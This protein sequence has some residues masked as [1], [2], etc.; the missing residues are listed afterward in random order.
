[1]EVP[2]NGSIPHDPS[3]M[4]KKFILPVIFSLY[5]ILLGLTICH[6]EMWRDELQPWGV[7]THSK[8]F[9]ELVENKKYEGHPILWFFLLWMISKFTEVPASIQAITF[10]VS[11]IAAWFII[12]KSP[13]TVLQKVLIVSGY[14]FF[15]EYTVISR[16]YVLA[17]AMIAAICSLWKSPEKDA[18]WLIVLFFLLCFTE[19]YA[20]IISVCLSITLFSQPFFR[21]GDT[22]RNRNGW[23]FPMAALSGFLL[24]YITTVPPDD[25]EL[26]YPVKFVFDR[27]HLIRVLGDFWNGFVPIPKLQ[28]HFWSSSLWYETT[29]A[30]TLGAILLIV[31][32]AGSFPYRSLFIFLLISFSGI[33]LFMY[34]KYSGYQ[35]H[36][37]HLFIIYI[38]YEW[39]KRYDP[40]VPGI[41]KFQKIS[42]A[43][44]F[45]SILS[46][47]TVLGISFAAA[48]WILPF[49]DG[50][51]TA[52]YIR[53]HFPENITVAGYSDCPAT[54]VANYLGKDVY[55][56]NNLR[57]S[58]YIIFSTKRLQPAGDLILHNIF[59]LADSLKSLAVILNDPV[60]VNGER[61]L[62][63]VGEEKQLTFQSE[64]GNHRILF[65]N[66]AYFGNS[67]AGG[68]SFYVYDVREIT[69]DSAIIE[70]GTS[71]K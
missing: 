7:V 66:L 41:S 70:S 15:Y 29:L 63:D 3:M 24:S 47:N 11:L 8:S 46:I 60:N 38:C 43:F 40:V 51:K 27:A 42:G 44:I 45:Y 14:Y 61:P 48:D 9:A 17:I 52:N 56:L 30:A 4:N 18:G 13:F 57:K 21:T 50:E 19:V 58:S 55:L 36:F 25:S 26:N 68:E 5:A 23:W 71:H 54:T 6:H 64:T 53:S 35:R 49:S 69:P 65:K 16:D 33:L 67:M 10:L 62:P 20:S 1:M 12:F 2:C 34:F 39:I 37:G 28:E 31:L 59:F 32:V 22:H